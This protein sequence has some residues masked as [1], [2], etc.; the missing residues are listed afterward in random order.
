MN[1]IYIVQTNDGYYINGVSYH[2]T[3]EGAEWACA[4]AMNDHINDDDQFEADKYQIWPA[5][6]EV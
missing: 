2:S 1:K 5:E 3:Q 6:L 4:H